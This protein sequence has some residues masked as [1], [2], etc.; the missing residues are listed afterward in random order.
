MVGKSY[1]ERDPEYSFFSAG[2]LLEKIYK[3]VFQT[4]PAHQDFDA[5]YR[6][7]FRTNLERGSNVE[8]INKELLTYDFEA[9]QAA[10][11]PSRDKILTFLGLQT[12]YDRYFIHIEKQRIEAP[13]HFWMRVSMGLA[14]SEKTRR[15]N[16]T[17]N[18]VLQH[19]VSTSSYKLNPN[20][21]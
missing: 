9:I 17:F 14:L 4:S 13:Q 19:V 15:P 21:I 1:I 6:S 16:Q 2:L 8:R 3:E 18:R 11:V 20:A 5:Q 7:S 10:L 12:L